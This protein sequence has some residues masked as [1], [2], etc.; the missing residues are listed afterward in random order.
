MNRLQWGLAAAIVLAATGAAFV[1]LAARTPW[2]SD[3]DAYFA[4]LGAIRDSVQ[5]DVPQAEQLER[6][7]A[8]FHAAQRSFA[9]RKWLYADIG[10]GLFAWG[11]TVA[12]L[13]LVTA[14]RG[15]RVLWR[16]TRSALSVAILAVLGL[17]AVAAGLLAG[18]VL[19]PYGRLLVPEWSHTAAIPIF[20][21]FALIFLLIPLVLALAG[22]PFLFGRR[23]AISLFTL[24]TPAP[25]RNMAATIVYALPFAFFL[26]LAVRPFATGGWALSP[27]GAMLAWLCLNGRA[28]II[29]PKA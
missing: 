16:S 22:A 12:L 25:I 7:T 28:L 2:H 23:E 29:A 11:V 10:Y 20:G 15:W 3:N 14:R 19:H 9:T 18:G 24:K 27:G 5:R 13:A 1:A 26:L 4:V 21:S 17:V 6:A 8:A